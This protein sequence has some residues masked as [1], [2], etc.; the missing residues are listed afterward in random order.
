MCIDD[1]VASSNMS[2]SVTALPD[3][4]QELPGLLQPRLGEFTF[5]F[6]DAQGTLQYNMQASSLTTALSFCLLKRN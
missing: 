3:Q 2:Q 1:L 5:V 6:R 4:C